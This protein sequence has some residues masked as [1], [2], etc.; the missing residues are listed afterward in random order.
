MATNRTG[1]LI[2]L[3]QA[4]GVRCTDR[5][6]DLPR[7]DPK[8][9]V[10][11]NQKSKPAEPKRWARRSTGAIKGLVFHQAAGATTVEG[12]N[13][14]HIGPNHISATGCPRACYWALLAQ[15]GMLHI[16]ND[17][18]DATWSQG[19]GAPPIQG[20]QGNTN[21]LSVCLLGDFSGPSYAGKQAGPTREQL[22]TLDKLLKPALTFL[23]LDQTAVFG[24]QHFGKENC[25]GSV[26]SG[27]IDAAREAGLKLPS[28]DT[29]WQQMLADLGYDLGRFGPLKNGVD[30]KWGN[31]SKMGLLAFQADHKC[32][33]TGMRDRMTAV[34]LACA[35]A[36]R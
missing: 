18:E 3:L 32:H 1:E 36:Q 6:S 10:W 12:L 13:N 9:K 7:H 21:Y 5:R 35:H 25:P 30:G 20:T 26:V 22:D 28:S 24:H 16:V 31:L 19:G 15:D 2:S 27:W 11:A 29:E 23:A 14:Y 4:N 34:E 17:I 33:Q 8:A